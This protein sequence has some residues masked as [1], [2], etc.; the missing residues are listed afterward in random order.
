MFSIKGKKV[1][2]VCLF[3]L[4]YFFAFSQS[5]G[6]W[7][8]KK[9]IRNITFDGLKSIKSFDVDGIT[10]PFIGKPFS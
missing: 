8:D 9:T 6:E 2:V 7:W 1:L 10:R 4:T 5:D 3:A